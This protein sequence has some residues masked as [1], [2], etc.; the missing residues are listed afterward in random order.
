MDL[1]T[2]AVSAHR[3]LTP[4]QPQSLGGAVATYLVSRDRDLLDLR[5]ELS[6]DRR[7]ARELAPELAM[8]EPVQFA[9][10]LGSA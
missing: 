10:A 1:S 2:Q 3:R 5:S 7:R 9:F 6:P 8:M 4:N